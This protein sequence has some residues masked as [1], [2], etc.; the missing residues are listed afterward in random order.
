MIKWIIAA[1]ILFWI[2]I[3]AGLFTRYV[4]KH[5]QLSYLFFLLTPLIDL[6]LIALTVVDLQSGAVATTAH[7]ISVIYIGVS[8]AYGKTM[9]GWADDKFQTYFLKKESTKKALYGI[10][11]GWHELKMLGRHVFAFAIGSVIFWL[12]LTYIDPNSTEAMR[13][14]WRIWSI[15]LLVD[16]VISISYLLFPKKADLK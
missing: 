9:I 3:L 14:V 13:N 12:I 7:G 8:I 1:E 15:A 4:L 2:A 6:A 5:K 11:K 10:E 16:G